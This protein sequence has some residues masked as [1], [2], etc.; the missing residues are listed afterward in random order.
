MTTARTTG[1][2]SQ[3]EAAARTAALDIHSYNLHLDLSQAAQ[4]SEFN[5][6][7]TIRLVTSDPEFFVDY[8]G[9]S[10]EE[11]LV[12]GKAVDGG[13][14]GTRIYLTGVPVGEEV[15]VEIAGTSAYSR[16]GQGLHRM[17]DT[18]DGNVYLYS[19]LEP[20]DA[21]RIFPCID[22]PDLKAVFHTTMVAP[23]G[24][25][26]LSNQPEMTRAEHDGAVT[27][28]F[29]P[30]PK[31]S[32]YLT[33]FAAGPYVSK[34][35]T[36]TSQDGAVTS[37]L[38]AWA[39][40]SMA[41][42]LDDEILEL[43][44]QGMDFFHEN[45][46]YPY[47]WGKYDSIFVPEYNLGAMENPG[48]VTFTERYLFRSHA[49]R[50]QRTG[51]ANTILHEMSH[52]WFGDLVTPRWWDD[53]W[54]KESFAEFMGADAS[55][56]ATVYQEAW[57]AFAGTRKNWA[58]TQDQ[59][60]TTHPIKA[61]IPDVDAARQNFDG[62]TYAKGAA[63]LKQLVH[64]I[65]RENFYAGARDYF[66]KHAFSAA[67]FEDLLEALKTHSDRDLDAWADA[68]LRTSGPDTLTPVIEDGTLYIDAE[69]ADTLRPHRLTV[70]FY[71]AGLELVESRDVD[72]TGEPRTEVGTAAGPLVV[73]NDGDHTYAKVRFDEQSLGILRKQLSKIEDELTRAVVWTALWQAT[74][75]G[76]WPAREYVG[77]VLDHATAE[78]NPGLMTTTLANAQ[79]AVAHY[80]D[81]DAD[82]AHFADALWDL[83]QAAE[84]GSDAQLILARATI[85]ALGATPD[86]SG[87]ERLRTV[88]NGGIG[89]LRLDPDVRWA[90][91]AALAARDATT[92]AELDAELERDNTLTGVAAHLGAR[93]AFP[94]RKRAAF[95]LVR[96]PGK[97]SNAQVDALI[98]AFHAP[99]GDRDAFAG[100]F[101]EVLDALWA[102][103]PIEIGNRL[104]RGLY[105]ETPETLE[106]TDKVLAGDIPGAL[107]RVL[108]ECQDGL[109][110]TL[111]VK[112]SHAQ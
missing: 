12:N 102:E 76:E 28:D 63:V 2:L 55:I 87:V 22:Q 107:R 41:E 89:K 25:A 35:K 42:Y 52:M 47:P 45:Y 30:T 61:E 59:L 9:N 56:H 105:P 86:A 74:R 108:L 40:A 7:S 33:S 109:A 13:F 58:Y 95:D 24:W 32:T 83:L 46:G 94:E 64:Y 92:D 79:Y 4:A 73:L 3:A 88:L 20:S 36:W 91:L 112:N 96:E 21:R 111:R 80:L 18:A 65:G 60:P 77:T 110:R 67:T 6:R 23:A 37:E 50:P 49:T 34:H 11:V 75:D 53:L 27:V 78:T 38:G 85:T 1:N 69:A 99:H 90:V 57:T 106:R 16:T 98:D 93:H 62:I 70:S 44:A 72:L 104:V 43:T 5:V 103:H 84:P 31:L 97:H 17:E 15:T 14:D 26:V 51:R 82:R 100:E 10:V 68:W 101:F 48:L 39:R 29:A 8:L 81:T 54:L 19:H 66:Q 71:S